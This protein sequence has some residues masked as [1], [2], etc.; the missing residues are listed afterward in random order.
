MQKIVRII[1]LGVWFLLLWGCNP[2]VVA[3]FT[4]RYYAT[5]AVWAHT[6][7]GDMLL[8][9]FKVISSDIYNLYKQ[10]GLFS[11]EAAIISKADRDADPLTCQGEE[12]INTGNLSDWFYF[13]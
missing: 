8:S 11:R 7:G 12:I 5:I 9:Y 1:I 2:S 4:G 13:N 6:P 10:R 3:D